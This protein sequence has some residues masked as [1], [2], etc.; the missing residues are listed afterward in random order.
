MRCERCRGLMIIDHFID[1][2]ETGGLWMRGWRC[3]AC[4]EVVDPRIMRHRKL[5]QSRI[6]KL[7]NAVIRRKKDEREIVHLSA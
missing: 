1:M 6:S 3:V 7:A 5:H 4:G 2:E